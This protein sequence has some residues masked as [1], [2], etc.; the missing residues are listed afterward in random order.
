MERF[1]PENSAGWRHYG[2]KKVAPLRRK[3]TGTITP[4]TKWLHYGEN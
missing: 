2:E 1:E 3:N 4:E